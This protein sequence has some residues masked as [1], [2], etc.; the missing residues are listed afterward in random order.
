MSTEAAALAGHA[1]AAQQTA[2]TR[3]PDLSEEE[4]RV[5]MGGQE[6]SRF[7]K[8]STRVIERALAQNV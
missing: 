1:H 2:L 8:R 3:M 6:F 5:M 4:K 7:F